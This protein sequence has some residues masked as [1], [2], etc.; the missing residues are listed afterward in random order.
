MNTE[1][2]VDAVKIAKNISSVRTTISDQGSANIVFI[3][4]L[5]KLRES[6]LPVAYDNWEGMNV[7]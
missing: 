6:I 1:G 3:R 7:I 5:K 2:H 4:K